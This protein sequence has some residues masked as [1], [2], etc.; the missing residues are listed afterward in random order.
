MIH[1]L[2]FYSSQSE[3]FYVKQSS[4]EQSLSFR[5]I[6]PGKS[7]HVLRLHLIYS[8]IACFGCKLTTDYMFALTLDSDFIVNLDTT[9]FTSQDV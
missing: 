7:A 9:A 2:A 8:G 1:C 4:N 5:P 6:I 3:N